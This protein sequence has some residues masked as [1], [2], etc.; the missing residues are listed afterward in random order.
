MESVVAMR[1]A[2][3]RSSLSLPSRSYSFEEG[4]DTRR[5]LG[6]GLR[7]EL[8]LRDG[9]TFDENPFGATAR[10]PGVADLATWPVRD[11]RELAT[12]EDIDVW[13]ALDGREPALDG[14]ESGICW[15]RRPKTCAPRSPLLSVDEAETPEAE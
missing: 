9:R 3:A 15:P 4:S 5:L 8:A 7:S 6:I 13:P 1:W 14:R 12:R 2:S 10:V 11:V